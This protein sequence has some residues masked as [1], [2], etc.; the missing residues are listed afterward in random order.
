[1]Y[2]K[3]QQT[4]KNKEKKIGTFEKKK[5]TLKKRSPK[6]KISI[7]EQE[8][9]NHLN[10]IRDTVPCFVCGQNRAN[11]P[12]EW[13]HV[14][15]RSSDKKNHFRLIPLCGNRHHRNGNISPHG[16]AKKW[17]DIFTYEDQLLEGARYHL[18]YLNMKGE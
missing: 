18:K 1:M 8:Y 10:S 7:K 5:Y 16:N 15:N 11:D 2:T 6:N 13:H 14:K 12:I 4:K 9:L 3:Q 17:R